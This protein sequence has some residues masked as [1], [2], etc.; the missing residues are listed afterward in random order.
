M[1]D[2]WLVFKFYWKWV[3]STIF[4]ENW[5]AMW[6]SQNLTT[7]R[8]QKSNFFLLSYFIILKSIPGND[9]AVATCMILRKGRA[10]VVLVK[11]SLRSILK[12]TNDWESTKLCILFVAARCRPAVVH[13]YSVWVLSVQHCLEVWN[14]TIGPLYF[15]RFFYSLGRDRKE[16]ILLFTL[17][18]FQI[19]LCGFFLP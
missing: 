14:C 10:D 15:L 18:Q 7:A 2:N 6:Q 8:F 4:T 11:L 5:L 12:L 13:W 19:Q 3:F 9:S 17:N 16:I 1:L